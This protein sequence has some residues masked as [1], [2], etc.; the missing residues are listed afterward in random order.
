LKDL[1]QQTKHDLQGQHRSQE[2]LGWVGLLVGVC[3]L[4]HP[5]LHLLDLQVLLLV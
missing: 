4:L 5:A 3:H 1:L 2:A